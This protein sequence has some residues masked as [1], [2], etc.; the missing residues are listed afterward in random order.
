MQHARK[1]LGAKRREHDI[2]WP[3]GESPVLG[4]NS[5]KRTACALCRI[6][7]MV[8]R[9]YPSRVIVATSP[10]RSARRRL[11]S[12]PHR[13]YVDAATRKELHLRQAT[14]R[15][16]RH[17]RSVQKCRKHELR[18]MLFD[19][20]ARGLSTA[21]ALITRRAISH[22]AACM[23]QRTWHQRSGILIL[24]ESVQLWRLLSSLP[25]RRDQWRLL[26]GRRATAQAHA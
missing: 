1:A 22:K 3:L 18:R 5:G 9:S 6:Y 20:R 16:G 11:G 10:T 7:F 14:S 19:G 8:R 26:F 24:R 4:A 12:L 23:Q 15:R 13:L 25:G 2:K 21:R 17:R